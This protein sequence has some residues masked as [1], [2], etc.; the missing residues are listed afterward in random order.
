[1]KEENCWNVNFTICCRGLLPLCERVC[2]RAL[3]PSVLNSQWFCS[4]LWMCW[5]FGCLKFFGSGSLKVRLRKTECHKTHWVTNRFSCPCGPDGARPLCMFKLSVARPPRFVLA[6]V[7]R[8][9]HV[10]VAK[11]FMLCRHQLRC[12]VFLKSPMKWSYIY[13][14][15]ICA[16]S[17]RETEQNYAWLMQHC[18]FL[19]QSNAL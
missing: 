16:A 11:H 1:M 10:Q 3:S 19:V 5:Y 9:I 13:Y 7:S 2:V 14:L 12:G 4:V 18:S 15:F 8:A 17:F 6:S